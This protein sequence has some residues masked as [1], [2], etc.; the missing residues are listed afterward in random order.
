MNQLTCLCLPGL[1]M[2][3]PGDDIAVL[4]AQAMVA[5]GMAPC[6]G[7]VLVIAQKII[8]K[9]EGRYVLLSDVVP[10]AEALALA[11]TVGRDPRLMEVVLSESRRVVRA[12]PGLLVV[13]HRL[14]FIMANAGI[15]QSNIT[16]GE[17]G[18]GERVLMLPHDPDGAA[19][20]LRDALARSTGADMGI[21]INDS[22]GRPWRRGVT[23]VA[24][25]AAGIPSFL[26][27]RGTLDVFGRPMQSTE[28][29]LGDELAALGSLMMGQGAEGS[30]VVHVR[31]FAHPGPASPASALLRPADQDRFR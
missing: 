20:G 2:V 13:E 1:P 5:C 27:M 29:A 8:S 11:Q 16:H 10:G 24:I 30:P 9:A 22:W 23:G 26:D 14:G 28:L 31:G 15:D 3:E 21:V 6:D 17:G 12:A 4:I 19:E 18:T 25:G 7:D